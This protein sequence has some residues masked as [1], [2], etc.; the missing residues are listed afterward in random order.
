MKLNEGL[1]LAVKVLSKTLDMTKV[2]PD[3]GTYMCVGGFRFDEKCCFSITCMNV[4]LIVV[5][6]QNVIN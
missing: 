4:I 2:T 6:Y 5:K 1:Q 3:K